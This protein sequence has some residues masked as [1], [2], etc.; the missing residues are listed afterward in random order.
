MNSFSTFGIITEL[1]DL[2]KLAF[3]SLISA[4][5][6]FNFKLDILSDL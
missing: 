5:M 1:D 4:V 2:Y 3:N 6:I